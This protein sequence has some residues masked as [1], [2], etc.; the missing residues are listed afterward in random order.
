M[1]VVFYI[2]QKS[3]ATDIKLNKWHLVKSSHNGTANCKCFASTGL[4]LG[5]EKVTFWKL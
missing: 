3:I 5:G 2:L 1:F 4:L